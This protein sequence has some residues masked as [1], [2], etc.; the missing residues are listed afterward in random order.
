M[1]ILFS[2]QIPFNAV[3]YFGI[4]D[5]LYVNSVKYVILIYATKLSFYYWPPNI[6]LDNLLFTC[7]KARKALSK[8]T[9]TSQNLE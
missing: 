7:F 2:S 9:T 5:S 1:I 8:S 6:R 4:D 3:S